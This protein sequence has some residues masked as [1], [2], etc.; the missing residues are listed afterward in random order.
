MNNRWSANQYQIFRAILGAYLFV[1]FGQLFFW[2]EEIFSN[3]GMI[4]DSDISPLFNLLPSIFWID[5]SAMTV[6]LVI[7]IATVSSMTLAI[8][9]KDKISALV[10]WYILACLLAKN[11]LISNPA[12]PYLGW[13]LLF[14]LCIPEIPTG[15][16]SIEKQRS[17]RLPKPLFFAAW[18][19][20]AV[21]YSYSGYTKILS[22]S[23]LSGDTIAF[24][25]NNPL[26]RDH[27]LNSF[28][29]WLPGGFLM[30]LTW[31]VMYL[32]LIFA[33]LALIKWI[34]PWI[35][36]GMLCVQLGFLVFLNFA[37]LTFPMLAFHLLTFDPGWLR[38]KVCRDL[39]V[40]Y[41]GGCALCHSTIRFIYSEDRD[42][43]MIFSPLQGELIKTLLSEENR[44]QLPDSIV[45][46]SDQKLL[47]KGQ[48]VVSILK[49]LGG[50]WL[51][52]G[53]LLNLLPTALLD[54]FY[55]FIGSRR[56]KWFGNA[57]AQCPI[58]SPA[59][60]SNLI[61]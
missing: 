12:L 27:L 29:L 56:I 46:L 36:L 43:Q 22:P 1:H 51:I 49:S 6:M 40:F 58:G 14:H 55:D 59:L 61:P 34:R 53:Y 38:K 57:Q 7:G 60:Q 45:V 54:V 50:L 39:V 17:W 26:A 11:P 52:L 23:W 20:L 3:T 44:T 37:D 10:L 24:V 16:D 5:D 25:L 8:G 9:Y 32:E 4:A 19:V 28:V 30:I 48:A 21:S 42:T 18:F 33:P 13:M 41:D 47:F 2:G 15:I 35:W 31:L